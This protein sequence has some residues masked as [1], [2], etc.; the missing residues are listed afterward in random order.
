MHLLKA[1]LSQAIALLLVMLLSQRGILP[2][3]PP[4]D[5]LVLATLQGVTA[6]LLATLMGSAAWWR[7]IHLTFA[8]MLVM[9]LSL[10]LPSWIYLLAFIVLVLVFW[11]SLRGQVPLFLSNRQTVQYLADW[12]RRDAPLKV[13]DLGSG[14][15]SFSRTLAQLRPDWHIVGIEDAPA[16]YWLSRQLGRHCKNLDLQNGDFWQHDLRPYDVVYAFLSP[17]PMPALWGKACS[18]MRSGTLLVSNSFPI[19]AE[20]AETILEV[21]DR[22]NTQLYCYLIP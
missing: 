15:G 21:G 19:P 17:V 3:T 9:M 5:L 20:R 7:L 13:L 18:E 4:K 22:R 6:A 10:Q 2:F 11:N 8:P 12:L 16:P 1:I 14:T